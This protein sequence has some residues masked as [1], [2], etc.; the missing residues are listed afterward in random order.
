MGRTNPTFRDVL[1]SLE[2]TWSTY[3]RGLRRRTQ[4]RFDRLFEYARR[5]ADA[6]TY[7]NPSEPMS[8]VLVSIDLEQEARLDDLE[9]RVGQLED[10]E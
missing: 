6:S 1:R 2:D 7:L 10:T 8:A 9:E 5:H 4:E 3:R